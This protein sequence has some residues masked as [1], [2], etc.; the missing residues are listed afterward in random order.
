MKV[1]PFFRV[2][3]GTLI[4]AAPASAG[5]LH[6]RHHALNTH[7]TGHG[8][9]SRSNIAY[10][11]RVHGSWERNTK[12]FERAHPFYA[13]VFR[14]QALFDSLA[15]IY[16]AHP[17]RFAFYHPCLSRVLSGALQ[18]RPGE[19]T[20]PVV[21]PPAVSDV[22]TNLPPRDITPPPDS[23]G[24]TNPPM[25]PVPEPSGLAL[26]ATGLAGLA[27]YSRRRRTGQG[28]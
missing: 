25:T 20:P 7:S 4:I 3:I 23:G 16:R 10:Y 17:Q 19:L 21:H 27:A 24:S 8:I 11:E 22:V 18:L 26:V 14:N 15:A 12:A 9:N 6:G 2:A 28:R 1:A 5:P 13:K